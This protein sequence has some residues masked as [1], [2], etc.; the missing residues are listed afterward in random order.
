MAKSHTRA[1]WTKR[2]LAEA[3]LQY[4]AED[5]EHLLPAAD[6]LSERLDKLGRLDWAMQ[7]S[8]LL[9]DPALYDTGSTQ[10]IGRLKGARNFTGPSRAAAARLASWREREAIRRDRPR[11]WILRDKALLDIARQLPATIDALAKIDSMPPKLLQR[12]GKRLVAIL[13]ASDDVQTDYQPPRPPG[14]AQKVLLKEMQALVAACAANLGIAAET[15]A[16]K[17]ELSAVIN[18]GDRTTR[19][20]TAWRRELIGR[21]LLQLL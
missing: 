7:D 8:Q 15:L 1:D 9:L 12:A 5:V 4:A 19:V 17:R 11:Q 20:F 14:E 16:P 2:P 6:I 13:A 3:V 21:Q 18:D 10:A